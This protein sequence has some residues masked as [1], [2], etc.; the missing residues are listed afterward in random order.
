MA[1]NYLSTE[2][3]QPTPNPPSTMRGEVEFRQSLWA[4]VYTGTREALAE[5]GVYFGPFPGDAGQNKTSLHLGQDGFKRVRVRRCGKRRF[6]VV[7]EVLDHVHSQ[8]LAIQNARAAH[9]KRCASIEAAQ[10]EVDMLP[11]TPSAYRSWF[12]SFFDGTTCLY[13]SSSTWGNGYGGY[14]FTPEARAEIDAALDSVRAAILRAGVI[15]SDRA[16]ASHIQQ[17]K[18]RHIVDDEAAA[19]VQSLVASTTTEGSGNHE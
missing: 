6:I 14:S 18:A 11:N 13:R 4:D 3:F 8:R 15:Q 17:I 7:F 1:T 16:R 9:A 5:S 2:C 10:R 12:A 19:F